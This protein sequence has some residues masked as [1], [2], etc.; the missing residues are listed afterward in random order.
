MRGIDHEMP[1][2]LL[3]CG[4]PCPRPPR[5]PPRVPLRVPPLPPLLPVFHHTISHRI[6]TPLPRPPTTQPQRTHHPSQ[7]QPSPATARCGSACPCPAFV[8]LPYVQMVPTVHGLDYINSI[9][10]PVRR[11]GRAAINQACQK[12]PG[13]VGCCCCC[14]CFCC[15]GPSYR[16]YLPTPATVLNTPATVPTSRERSTS[17]RTGVGKEERAT[18]QDRTEVRRATASVRRRAFYAGSTR[19][20]GRD[21]CLCLSCPARGVAERAGEVEWSGGVVSW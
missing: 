4:S 15:C 21:I 18:T 8:G 13:R 1:D 10:A 12:W 5:V 6:C 17:E 20:G 2:A 7:A 16:A 19:W 3:R 9:P 11:I 14:C